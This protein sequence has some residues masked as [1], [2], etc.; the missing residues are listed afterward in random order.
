MRSLSLVG[1]EFSSIKKSGAGTGQKGP[2]GPVGPPDEKLGMYLNE[3]SPL[4][5]ASPI[6]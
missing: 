4:K 6:A 3:K 2:R 1:Q 5:N